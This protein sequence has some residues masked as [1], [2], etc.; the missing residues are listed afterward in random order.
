MK[1]ANIIIWVLCV[2]FLASGIFLS[3]NE[4]HNV[5]KWNNRMESTEAI[6]ER[7]KQTQQAQ[8]YSQSLLSVIQDLA[9]EN[10]LLCERDA[11][12]LRVVAEFEEENRRLTQALDN[13]VEHLA[14]QQTEINDLIDQNYQLSYKVD[15]LER[16]L[17]TIEEDN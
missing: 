5:E 1:I 2:V 16:A 15:V 10:T 4:S 12:T 11:K 13:S 14:A 3:V 8:E 6:M 7:T 9:H 17:Y